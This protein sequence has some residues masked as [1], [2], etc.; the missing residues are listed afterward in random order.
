MNNKIK[1]EIDEV[2]MKE[3]DVKGDECHEYRVSWK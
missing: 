3:G 2:M 1:K